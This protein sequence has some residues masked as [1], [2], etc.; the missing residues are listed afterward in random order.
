MTPTLHIEMLT[1]R[2]R[3]IE[4]ALVHIRGGHQAYGEAQKVR[5]CLMDI[6]DLVPRNPG[7]DAAVDDLHRHVCAFIEAEPEAVGREARRAALL[8]DAHARLLDRLAA[9]GVNLAMPRS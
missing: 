7:L 1:E 2:I 3:I 9:A 4:E 5:E 6:L 8:G